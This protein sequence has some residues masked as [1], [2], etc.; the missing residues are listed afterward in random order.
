MACGFCVS[1]AGSS[2]ELLTVLD[3][4]YNTGNVTGKKA[5]MSGFISDGGNYTKLAYC[6][7]TGKVVN[8]LTTGLTT[9]GLVGKFN[10]NMDHCFNAGDVVS[11]CNATGGLVGY[12]SYGKEDYPGRILNSFNIG[13]VTCDGFTG[14]S[15]NGNAGGLAGY[16]ATSNATYWIEIENSFNAGVVKSDTRVGGI[17]G[18]AFS[19]YPVI[20][21]CYN[22][23]RVIADND[24][25][26]ATVY[27]TKSEYPAEIVENCY[28]DKTANPAAEAVATGLTTSQFKE[29]NI[30][31]A[32]EASADGGYP[33]IKGF[34]GET[35]AQAALK[36]GA[37]MILVGDES[38]QNHGNVTGNVTLI[39]PEGTSW[40]VYET[41]ASG[42]LAASSKMT[43]DGNTAKPAEAGDVVLV[44]TTADKMT[45]SFNL[46]LKPVATGIDGV[47]AG[48]TVESVVYVDVQGRIVAQPTP[49]NAYIVRTNYT[50]GTSTVTK[51]ISR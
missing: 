18:G 44:A 9:A 2:T 46:T 42:A 36:G 1:T 31:D 10:G 13:N 22:S 8:T 45:R 25:M 32:F 24:A 6:Y 5:A 34:D 28:Y 29:L 51:K 48:K 39:A 43:I 41:S 37:V 14:T 16:L 27:A 11:A 47:D 30:S 20:R 40:A 21:N 23:G 19:D 17:T 50:D 7:N 12:I 3:H 26:S 35:V 15:T 49:G 4:C 33:V 38:A